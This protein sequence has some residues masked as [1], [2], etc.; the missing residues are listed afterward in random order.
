MKRGGFN[1]VVPEF[2]SKEKKIE[3]QKGPNKLVY[4]SLISTNKNGDM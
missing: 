2:P 3:E 1:R 4:K